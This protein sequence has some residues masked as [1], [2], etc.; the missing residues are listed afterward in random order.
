MTEKRDISKQPNV[1]RV[2][3]RAVGDLLWPEMPGRS[4]SDIGK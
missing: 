2:E 1:A 3:L 4:A